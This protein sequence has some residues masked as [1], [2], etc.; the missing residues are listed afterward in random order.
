[1]KLRFLLLCL[2]VVFILS[3]VKVFAASSS[4]ILVNIAPPNPAPG[5]DVSITLS[6]YAN[7]LD[8]VLITWSVNGTSILSGIGKKTFLVKA[9]PAG[10][11]ASIRAVISLPEGELEKTITIRP[12][13]MI[14]LWQATDS[15]VPPFYKGKA[16]PTIDSE[17][18]VVAMPEI[19]SSVGG[20]LVNSK[21]MTYIW[22]KDYTNDQEASGYGKN[23]FV[24]TND[25][26]E[27]SNTISVVAGTTDQKSTAEASIDVGTVDPKIV[28]YKN[29]GKMGTIW[30]QALSDQYRIT[31]AEVVEAVPYFISP[32]ELQHPNLVWN[33]YINDNIVPVPIYRKNFMPLRV[34]GGVSGTSKLK[35]IIENVSR[36][37]QSASKEIS[38]EF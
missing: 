10:S 3:G 25:Y 1:M 6:S 18:K 37:F 30:E 16:L 7:N 38:I 36:I 26:L 32:K 2:V 11:F 13:E 28:F 12:N 15:Y 23:S 9:P 19:K 33:W 31:V 4:S 29:D 22:K 35:L 24:Y 34:E 20:A 27:N 14:L 8:S 17:I 21:N 5:E